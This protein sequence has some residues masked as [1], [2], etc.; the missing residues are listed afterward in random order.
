[1]VEGLQVEQS[2]SLALTALAWLWILPA[3]FLAI[4][5]GRRG[6]GALPPE[7]VLLVAWLGLSLLWALDPRIVVRDAIKL[8]LMAL[9]CVA[10]GCSL[11]WREIVEAT[12]RLC[13]V[14]LILSGLLAVLV[15]DYGMAVG[16]HRGL[17]QGV[18]GHKNQFGKFCAFALTFASIVLITRQGRAGPALAVAVLALA[19]LAVSGSVFALLTAVACVSYV[20]VAATIARGDDEMSRT[21]KALI[22]IGCGAMVLTTAWIAAPFILDALGRDMSFSGRSDVWALAFNAIARAPLLGYGL[23]NFWT[24]QDFRLN[25]GEDYVVPH[26]HNGYIELLLDGGAVGMLLLLALLARLWYLRRQTRHPQVA[27]VLGAMTVFVLFSG[28]AEA[29]LVN[30][31]FYLAMLLIIGVAASRVPE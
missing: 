7:F 18:F 1:M 23:S 27:A 3:I 12:L 24:T 20:I 31:N 2:Q 13:L 6:L 11:S 16:V 28:I 30:P 15:P 10:V 19:G 5:A 17:V 21:I 26:S 14:L 22:F 8:V 29:A 4:R 25:A 9:F